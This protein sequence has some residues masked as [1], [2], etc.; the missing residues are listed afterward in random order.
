MDCPKCNQKFRMT[1]Y[2]R[3]AEDGK[4]ML[5]YECGCKNS[6]VTIRI[7]PTEQQREQLLRQA[8]RSRT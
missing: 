2:E 3:T 1:K 4:P 8:I 7:H 6:H 5:V